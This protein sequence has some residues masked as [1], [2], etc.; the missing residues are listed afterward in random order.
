MDGVTAVQARI[1]EIQTRFLHR[2]STAPGNW[3]GAAAA[4]GLG[5]TSAAATSAATTTGSATAS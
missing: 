4:A 2:P 3:A 1:S 5:G